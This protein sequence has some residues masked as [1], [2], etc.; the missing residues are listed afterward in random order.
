MQMS[1]RQK[2][3]LGG[4]QYLAHSSDGDGTVRRKVEEA[5]R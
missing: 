2:H 3:V 5:K 4:N 1:A